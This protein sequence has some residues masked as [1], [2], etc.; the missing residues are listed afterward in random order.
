MDELSKLLRAVNFQFSNSS[1]LSGRVSKYTDL[2]QEFFN[3]RTVIDNSAADRIVRKALADH[4][5]KLLTDED[6]K[7]IQQRVGQQIPNKRVRL[8]HADFFSS[9]PNSFAICSLKSLSRC[10]SRLRK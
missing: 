5:L 7:I 10:L 9:S 1:D 3:I 4:G 6:L 8:G 2:L